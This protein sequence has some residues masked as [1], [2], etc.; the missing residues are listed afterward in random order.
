MDRKVGP[1]DALVW[2]RFRSFLEGTLTVKLKRTD[3]IAVVVCYRMPLALDPSH[4]HTTVYVTYS[5]A[6][7]QLGGKKMGNHVAVGPLL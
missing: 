6:T 3:S 1:L 7:F 2:R 4:M 5:H